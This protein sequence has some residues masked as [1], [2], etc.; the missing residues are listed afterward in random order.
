MRGLEFDDFYYFRDKDVFVVLGYKNF[1]FSGFTGENFLRYKLRQIHSSK[2]FNLFFRGGVWEGDGIFTDRRKVFIYV[3][4]ADCYPVF[5]WDEKIIA[6]LHV[7]WKGLKRGI[8]SKFFST[9]FHSKKNIKALVGYGICKKCY[10]VSPNFSNFFKNVYE[11]NGK[12]YFDL[13]KEINEELKK[14]GVKSIYNFELCT[15]ENDFLYSYR[16]GDRRKRLIAG[17]GRL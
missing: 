5:V 17:I 9:L 14:S 2:V 8:I 13:R 10:E 12:Y 4:V 3:K 11:E 1:R 16:G 15:Q 6:V 7:G